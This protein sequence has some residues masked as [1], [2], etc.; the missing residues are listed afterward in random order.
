MS[1]SKEEI[2]ELCTASSKVLMTV[3]DLPLNTDENVR[4]IGQN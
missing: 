4:L 2:K 3:C 1:K